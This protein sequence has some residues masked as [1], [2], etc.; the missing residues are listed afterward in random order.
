MCHEIVE[1]RTAFLIQHYNLA[2]QDRTLSLETAQDL[3]KQRFKLTEL[4][5]LTRHQPGLVTVDIQDPAKAVV[6]QLIYPIGM[7][8]R[9]L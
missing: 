3:L 1:V 6:L 7:A 9:L 5:P 2:I 4:V 8:D